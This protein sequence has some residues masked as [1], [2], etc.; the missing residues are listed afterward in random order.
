MHMEWTQ[1]AV[2]VLNHC[3]DCVFCS[4]AMAEGASKGCLRWAKSGWRTVA[5]NSEEVKN[6][7][8]PRCP[9][10][11][12]VV[13][14]NYVRAILERMS[15][16]LYF[17]QF[18]TLQ[19]YAVSPRHVSRRCKA[20]HR[21][22]AAACNLAGAVTVP[23]YALHMWHAHSGFWAYEPYGLKK[24][25]NAVAARVRDLWPFGVNG[26][27]VKVSARSGPNLPGPWLRYVLRVNQ[28]DVKDLWPPG[29]HFRLLYAT[30]Q[31]KPRLAWTW[32][33]AERR[34]YE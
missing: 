10:H 21:A 12:S 15:G 17:G 4:Q 22:V 29:P 3:P 11:G 6:C 7:K 27:P 30:A 26:K 19:G 23:H 31:A 18:L 24:V 13:R 1:M 33:D 32:Q 5:I 28:G 8:N 20:I 9:A 25:V 14:C 34:Q 16:E 2:Y